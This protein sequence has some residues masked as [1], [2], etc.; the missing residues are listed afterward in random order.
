MA[1][2]V[3]TFGMD[4]NNLGNNLQE[5]LLRKDASTRENLTGFTSASILSLATFSWLNPL[6]SLGYHNHLTIDNIPLLPP[7]DRG[8]Q[9]CNKFDSIWEN[10]KAH[11]PE[12]TPSIAVALIK[13]F[14]A[15]ILV[16][17]VLTTVTNVA[18][19]VGPYLIEDFVEFLGGRERFA[20]EG[21]VLVFFFCVANVVE[22]LCQRYYTVMMFRYCVRVRACLT[23]MIYRKVSFRS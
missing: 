19:F 4:N 10:L 5:P 22:C 13:N 2:L 17:G 1:T 9:V 16:T 11:H 14:W 7:Q 15:T 23:A 8:K 6:L 18:A 12:R 20:H 21:I 3:D